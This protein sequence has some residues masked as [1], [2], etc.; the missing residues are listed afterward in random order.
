MTALAV[1]LVVAAGAVVLLAVELLGSAPRRAAFAAI[2]VLAAALA[3]S[4]F[5]PAG[6]AF[7]G[8]FAADGAAVFFQRVV[9]VLAIVGVLGSIDDVERA[10]PGRQGEY[11]FLIL[12]SVAGMTLLSGARDLL[13]LVLSFELMGIPL[14]VLAAYEKG[15][16]AAEAG[17]KLFLV[18]AAST[19]IT[20][21]GLSFLVGVS[22]GTR[23][24]AI[25]AAAPSPLLALG[26]VLVI[27]GMAF[28]LGAVPFHMWVPDTYQG[29]RGPFVAFLASAPKA[30]AI[31]A[32][33]RILLGAAPALGETWVPA[34]LAIAAASMLIG[35]FLAVPQEKLR[36][37]LGY[38]GIA[39]AGFLL[40]GLATGAGGLGLVLFYVAA[41]T[42]TNAGVFLVAHAVASSDAG[43]DDVA[44][45]SGLA[46]RTPWLALALLLFLLS[47]AGI[48]FVAGFWAKLYV[49]LA[50]ARAGLWPWVGLGALLS[51]VALFAYLRVA[52][53]AYLGA[54]ARETPVAVPPALAAAIVVCLLVVVGLGLV[55]GPLLD[56]AEHAAP[57]WASVG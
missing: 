33:G 53:E 38:S 36:R 26:L 15:A 46:R 11:F 2:L 28:K 51:V 27:A 9:L 41:Y 6:A 43:G 23:L 42:F 21:F 37:L 30:A 32:L 1:P 14:Y 39:H 13:L 31:A 47:L 18:G 48:P 34:L 19:G 57:T 56:A 3:A 8:A 24:S 35:T 17:L 12:A 4:S 20:L 22:G 49:F 7:G 44:S 29:A 40:L 45:C 54:P 10:T 25:A 16:R 52:R 50:A 55:P 5:V